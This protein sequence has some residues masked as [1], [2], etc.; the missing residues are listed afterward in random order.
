MKRVVACL[1]LA[2]AVTGCGGSDEVDQPGVPAQF[3][4]CQVADPRISNY[5]AVDWE[6][7]VTNGTSRQD[8]EVTVDIYKFDEWLGS[9]TGSE[10]LVPPGVSFLVTGGI[11]FTQPV[12]GRKWGWSCEVIA[13]KEIPTSP[14]D[15]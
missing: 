6:V 7:P 12:M 5:Y 15:P 13:T 14:T 4:E 2:V 9:S 8:I 3:G 11:N 1:V 10:S